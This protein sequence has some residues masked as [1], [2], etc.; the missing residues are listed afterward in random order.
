MKGRAAR[1]SSRRTLT[2]DAA[3]ADQVIVPV[4][5]D[6]PVEPGKYYLELADVESGRKWDG[7]VCWWTD[8]ASAYTDGDAYNGPFQGDLWQFLR[9]LFDYSYDHFGPRTDGVAAYTKAAG[10]GP[11]RSARIGDPLVCVSYWEQF[12]GG[13]DLWSS[14]WYPSACTAMADL[15]ASQGLAEEARHYTS[16]RR[17]ADDAF[18]TTFGRELTENGTSVFRYVAAVDWDGIEHDY[19]HA[20]YNLEAIAA[21]YR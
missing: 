6:E 11:N 20:H 16:L 8:P 10:G 7:S 21:G 13:R 18:R 4:A 1:K 14:L 19:G 9:L 17:A 2:L 12:G 15:A 3:H 5:V